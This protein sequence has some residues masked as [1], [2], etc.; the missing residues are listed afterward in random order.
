ML[1]VDRVA[2]SEM[3]FCTFPTVIQSCTVLLVVLCLPTAPADLMSLAVPG[4]WAV[5]DV[6]LG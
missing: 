2:Q 6:T 4:A 1:V 3:S 5:R